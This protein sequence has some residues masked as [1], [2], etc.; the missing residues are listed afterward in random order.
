M[1]T[2][3]KCR[4]RR[5]VSLGEMAEAFWTEAKALC[6]DAKEAEILATAAL[7][8]FLTWDLARVK[9]LRNKLLQGS[10]AYSL[11]KAS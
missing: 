10:L 11:R 3:E 9:S 2:V 4:V 8:N 5:K 1:K 6:G 7:V